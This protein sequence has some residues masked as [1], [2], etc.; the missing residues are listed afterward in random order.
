MMKHAALL[1]AFFLVPTLALADPPA[2]CFSP[3]ELAAVEG[4]N[5]SRRATAA[6]HLVVPT[7]TPALLSGAAEDASGVVRRV[8]LPAGQKLVALTFDL[9]EAGREVAGYDAAVVDAL[10]AQKAPA[11]FFM[12][13]RWAQSHEAR[14]MQLLAD[15]LFEIG[16]HTY[17]HANLDHADAAK[18]AE[19]IGRTETVLQGLRERIAA[20]CPAVGALPASGVFR[21][22]YGSCSPESLAAVS[23]MGETAIQW[24]VVSGDPS[25]I[26][27]AP[28]AKAVLA[29]VKPGSIIVMHA[30]GRGKHTGAALKTIIPKLRAAGYRFV[31][32]SELLKAGAPQRSAACYIERPGDTARYDHPTHKMEPA[33]GGGAKPTPG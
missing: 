20:V 13:G 22:P 33:T 27:A 24:D 21:F 31:T 6:D 26:G 5:L 32:V 1:A 17:D 28:M 4:E 11:T 15:P 23:A 14:A 29:E 18:V 8:K 7:A 3:G 9:C 30:N 25:G 12:G 10:R 16:N 19:E 2:A